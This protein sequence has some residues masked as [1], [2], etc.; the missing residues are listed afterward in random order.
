MMKI[1][2]E[3]SKVTQFKGEYRWLSNFYQSPIELRGVVFPSAEAAYQAS[4]A[5]YNLDSIFCKLTPGQSKRL[6]K[7]IRLREDWDEVKFD[8][9]E[10]VLRIKFRDHDLRQRLIAT[11]DAELYEGNSW[12]DKIWGC[13][14]ETL[15]GEN[16]LGKL[17]M[18]LRDEYK[19]KVDLFDMDNIENYSNNLVVD[20]LMKQQKQLYGKFGEQTSSNSEVG[21]IHRKGE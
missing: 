8:I 2:T 12:G 13:D 15:E 5:D 9:M 20:L 10:M 21:I 6:G 14:W 1:T 7:G 11:G 16:R 17:L 3:V 4:K 19:S 18:K